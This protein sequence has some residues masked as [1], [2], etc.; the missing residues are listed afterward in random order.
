LIEAF[1]LEPPPTADS[2][3]VTNAASGDA[4]RDCNGPTAVA[5]A[6]ASHNA[7]GAPDAALNACGYRARNAR[8]ARA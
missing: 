4:L 7:G 3:P 6:L 1:A 8:A 5:R 2:A